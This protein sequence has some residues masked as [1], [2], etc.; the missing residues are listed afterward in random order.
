MM[1]ISDLNNFFLFPL[2]TIGIRRNGSADGENNSVSK[3]FIGHFKSV[4]QNEIFQINSSE[5]HVPQS[6]D[7]EQITEAANDIS[8]DS[9]NSDDSTCSKGFQN[10]SDV[11]EIGKESETFNDIQ[12]SDEFQECEDSDDSFVSSLEQISG[13]DCPIPVSSS[14]DGVDLTNVVAAC[15]NNELEGEFVEDTNVFEEN[16]ADPSSD[17]WNDNDGVVVLVKENSSK[18]DVCGDKEIEMDNVNETDLKGN[19]T[20]ITFYC[21]SVDKLMFDSVGED[22]DELIQEITTTVDNSI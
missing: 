13:N 8:D 11:Y 1:I 9:S 19:T 22:C 7:D 4:S 12:N 3:R 18:S 16:F 6:N 5:Q 21:E 17:N 20:K 2:G 15:E 10:I 14:T